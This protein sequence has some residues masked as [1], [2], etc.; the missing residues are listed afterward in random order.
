MKKFWSFIK[1]NRKDNIGISTLKKNGQKIS[2]PKDKADILNHQF[3]SAFTCETSVPEDILPENSP[4]PPMPDIT[5]TIPGVQKLLQNLKIHKAAGP[6]DITPRV[7]KELSGTIAPILTNLYSKSYISA[8]IPDEWRKANVVPVYKKGSKYDPGNYRLISLTCIACKLMEHIITS[9]IMK[10]ANRHNI[11]YWLQHGF[12][13]LRSCETQLIEFISDITNTMQSGAQTDVLIMDFSKA[14]DKVGHQRLV[15]KLDY[16]GIQGH[17]NKWIEAF[18]S[19]RSQTVVLEGARSEAVEVQSG[20]PQGSV[21]G[22]CLFLFYINDLPNTVQ[23]N[24]RLFADDTIMYLAINRVGDT[25]ILQSDLDKL[26]QWEKK[27]M[28]EFHPGKCQI[29]SITRNKTKIEQNYTLH[30]QVLERVDSAKYLGVTLT[31]DLRWNKHIEK[32][33]TKANNTLS[34]L[35]RNLQVKSPELKTKAYNTLVRPQVEYAATVWDP[36]KTHNIQRVEMV[37]RRAARYTLNRYHNTSSVSE[38]LNQLGWTPLSVRREIQRLA[39]MYKIRNGLVAIDADKYLTPVKRATR[40]AHKLGY[41]VPQSSADYHLYS[42]FPRT[43]RGW[44]GLPEELVNLPSIDT[45]RAHLLKRFSS[46]P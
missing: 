41:L 36:H 44:N 40:H 9:S 35:R 12:R 46:T 34:F 5:F 27:W 24:V 1:H 42:F 21:L 20:V 8:N 10:H 14:F 33:S 18:L 37:Q 29:L 38:M 19:H 43:I 39:M 30:G 25:D 16:Y 4:H 45:F 31:S 15:R 26:A 3:K 6:D 11:L 32:I 2:D 28:M 13:E 17:T 23:S 7:L 22:P